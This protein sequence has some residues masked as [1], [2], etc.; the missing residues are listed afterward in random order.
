[1]VETEKWICQ[2]TDEQMQKYESE[3][4]IKLTLVRRGNMLYAYLDD[5]YMPG[6]G[7]YAGNG[8]RTLSEEYA[9]D[10]VQVGFWEMSALKDKDWKFN[11]NDNPLTPIA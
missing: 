3:E 11:I 2:L 9:D 5:V 8:T 10:K 7:A 4:G 1:M 6:E